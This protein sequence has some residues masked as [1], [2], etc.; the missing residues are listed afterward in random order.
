MHAPGNSAGI[1]TITGNLASTA[2]GTGPSMDWAL[3]ASGASNAG[4]TIFDQV[5]VSGDLTFSTN[6]ACTMAFDGVGSTVDWTDAFWDTNQQWTIWQ[7]GGMTLGFGDLSLTS[8]DWLDANGQSFST[9]RSG[10][11]FSLGLGGNGSDV[12]L[13]YVAPVPE[14]SAWAMLVTGAA[15]AAW[16]SRRRLLRCTSGA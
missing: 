5:L 12:V 2:G 1:Q 9:S 13:F 15:V 8:S 7:V 16:R 10:A 4:T 6:M 11:T 14:P 3:F